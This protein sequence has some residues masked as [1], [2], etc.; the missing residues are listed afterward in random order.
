MKNI[1]LLSVPHTYFES[2]EDT[3]KSANALKQWL[4]RSVLAENQDTYILFGVSRNSVKN[5]C[6]KEIRNGVGRPRKTFVYNT[7]ISHKT[8]SP[9]LH[10][11]IVGESSGTIANL[12]IERFLS[13]GKSSKRIYK[14]IIPV[15]D[16]EK[17][18]DY[19]L[20]Q[21]ES[22]REIKAPK[23]SLNTEKGEKKEKEMSH[24]I[25]YNTIKNHFI[26]KQIKSGVLLDSSNTTSN[27]N[28]GYVINNNIND[29][30]DKYVIDEEDNISVNYESDEE[31]QLHL[32]KEAEK[33][34]EIYEDDLK[35]LKEVLELINDIAS[36]D[37]KLEYLRLIEEE[38]LKCQ[39]QGQMTS[40]SLVLLL[41]RI[42]DELKE[43]AQQKKEEEAIKELNRAIPRKR[44]PEADVDN[45]FL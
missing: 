6:V 27:E 18:K 34:K 17:T 7:N 10:I 24:N 13:K 28:S 41:E 14:S 26:K 2:Y 45:R 32:L 33:E 9:H 37:K 21:S 31:H 12:I 25:F 16:L 3:V 5:G 19:I 35:K 30:S 4:K 20:K 43:I 42:E 23:V 36:D 15:T 29:I 1:Y 11:L 38:T 40:I 44:M 22:I 8:T 39:E